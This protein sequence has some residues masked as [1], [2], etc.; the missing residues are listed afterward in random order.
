MNKNI[1]NGH[2]VRKSATR[3]EFY[4]TQ[5]TADLFVTPLGDAGLYARKHIFCNCDGP[6]SEIYKLLKKKFYEWDLA[7]LEAC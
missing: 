7:S 6:E 4:T 2:L 3:D 1:A 5:N